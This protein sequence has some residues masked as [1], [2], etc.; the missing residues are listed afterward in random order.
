MGHVVLADGCELVERHRGRD[1]VVLSRVG[2][3]D[4]LW[5]GAHEA[6]D[7]RVG[8]LVLAEGLVVHEEVDEEAVAVDVVDPVCELLG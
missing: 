1:E 2:V 5:Q 8:P 6:E 3:E 7:A 4:G